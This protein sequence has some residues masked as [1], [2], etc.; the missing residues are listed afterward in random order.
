MKKE[1]TIVPKDKCPLDVLAEMG[2]R[3]SHS[4]IF[5]HENAYQHLIN[6]EGASHFTCIPKIP[7]QKACIT[8]E[9]TKDYPQTIVFCEVPPPNGWGEIVSLSAEDISFKHPEPDPEEIFFLKMSE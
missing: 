7:V 5:L 1:V 4:W 9:A 3:I 2:E 8:W 6:S